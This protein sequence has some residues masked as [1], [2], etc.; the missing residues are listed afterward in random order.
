MVRLPTFTAIISEAPAAKPP[1]KRPPFP[2][3]LAALERA[4]PDYGNRLVRAAV[5]WPR[6]GSETK[7]LIRNRVGADWD[8]LPTHKRAAA[9]K[10]ARDES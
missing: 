5:A 8:R 1:K 4:H 6:R 7:D 10:G 9:I 3:M 2:V